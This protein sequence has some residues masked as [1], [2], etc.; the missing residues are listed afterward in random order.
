MITGTVPL[1]RRLTTVIM[2]TVP[3]IHKNN[4]PSSHDWVGGPMYKGLEAWEDEAI[5]PPIILPST[6]CC[7]RNSH[8]AGCVTMFATLEVEGFQHMT[9]FNFRP[10]G[11]S[12]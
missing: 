1:I 9:Q 10:M 12:Y 11:H 5:H 2:G 8:I 4:L 6:S 3:E 7:Q